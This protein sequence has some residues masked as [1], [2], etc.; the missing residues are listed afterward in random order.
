M[1]NAGNI[2]QLNWKLVIVSDSTLLRYLK[3]EN[4]ATPDIKNA[5][6]WYQDENTM[7]TGGITTSMISKTCWQLLIAP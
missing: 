1:T 4:V 3:I 6:T 2:I 7:K 5:I